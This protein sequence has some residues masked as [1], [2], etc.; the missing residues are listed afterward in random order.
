MRNASMIGAI[1]ALATA[2]GPAASLAQGNAGAAGMHLSA[3]A[4]AASA[5]SAQAGSRTVVGVDGATSL[6]RAD[7]AAGKHGQK[8][9]NVVRTRGANKP[10]FCPPGQAKKPGLGSRFQC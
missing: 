8:G 3:S 1:F 6:A 2:V 9:R 5:A 4:S 7:K 10:G